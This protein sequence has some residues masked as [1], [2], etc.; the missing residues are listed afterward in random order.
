MTAAEMR[1]I[2]RAWPTLGRTTRMVR[3]KAE[4]MNSGLMRPPEMLEIALPTVKLRIKPAARRTARRTRAWMSSLPWS[5]A[6]TVRATGWAFW[7]E[8]F[9][10]MAVPFRRRFF[11]GGALPAPGRR[12]PSRG[13]EKRAPGLPGALQ[14]LFSA[15]KT[16]D[17]PTAE[18]L[19]HHQFMD[20]RAMRL[21]SG[22]P[23]S[24]R[25][26]GV[27]VL[28]VTIRARRPARKGVFSDV[29]FALHVDI[30]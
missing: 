24:A 29:T 12:G 15:Q 8:S 25:P 27:P 1:P 5:A 14:A 4:M 2:T 11:S 26:E 21:M 6:A 7:L 19:R 13:H 22:A 23:L 18:R 20:V 16:H 3:Q 10:D 28:G 30:A 17:R 9:W